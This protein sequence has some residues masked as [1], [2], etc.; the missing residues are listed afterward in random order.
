MKITMFIGGFAPGGAERIFTDLSNYLS[1]RHQVQVL[2]WSDAAPYYGLCRQIRWIPLKRQDYKGWL[3]DQMHRYRRLKAFIR[4]DDSDAYIAF[5][6]LATYLLLSMKKEIRSPVMFSIRISP[7]E[8]YRPCYMKL[9]AWKYMPKA[10]GIVFQTDA[11]RQ[12]FKKIRV[13]SCAVIPN[14]LTEAFLNQR[15]DAGEK[16]KRIISVG[17]LNRQKNIPLLI[18]AFSEIADEFPMYDLYIFGEGEERERLEQLIFKQGLENRVYLPG[19]KKNIKEEL[20]QSEIF[21][22]SSDY[23]GISNALLEALSVGLPSVATDCVGGGAR[24]LIQDGENGI[25]VPVND[26]QALADGMR[27]LLKDTELRKRLSGNAVKVNED[28][29]PERILKRWETYIS[30]IV[31]GTGG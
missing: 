2:T 21:V 27:R 29:A 1:R 10:D 6:P 8:E 9:L 15:A 24:M 22:M 4:K 25:L 11:Q 23:E 7:E 16:K 19:V 13:R 30:R 14:S 18:G 31:K 12:Y 3:G 5:L 17:R 20:V 28:Y 26:R